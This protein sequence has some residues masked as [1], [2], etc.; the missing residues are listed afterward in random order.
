MLI[1]FGLWQQ[2]R[3]LQDNKDDKIE[4]NSLIDYEIIYMNEV[5]VN[6]HTY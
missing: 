2:K 5:H 1:E 6:I 3:P 4:T